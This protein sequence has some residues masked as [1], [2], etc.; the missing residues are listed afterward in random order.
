MH[1]IKRTDLTELRL[2]KSLAEL[3]GTSKFGRYLE[4]RSSWRGIDMILYSLLHG[5]SLQ[6]EQ[7][8]Y[9]FLTTKS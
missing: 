3:L 8:T 4:R 1:K 9:T 2:A 5:T 6:V 7:K